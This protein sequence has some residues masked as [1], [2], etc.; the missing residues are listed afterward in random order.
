MP[1][2]GSNLEVSSNM[3][4]ISLVPV[5]KAGCLFNVHVVI[6]EPPLGCNRRAVKVSGGC[7]YGSG[8]EV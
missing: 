5:G 3:E 2:E 6:F 1:G 7:D 8:A 4:I